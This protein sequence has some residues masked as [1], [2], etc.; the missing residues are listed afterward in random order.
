MI[1]WLYAN[2]DRYVN[3][4]HRSTKQLHYLKGCLRQALIVFEIPGCIPTEINY[5]CVRSKFD[6]TSEV[7]ILI[8]FESNLG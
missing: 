5:S 3:G 2:I 8:K 6:L 1:R 7:K 4:V